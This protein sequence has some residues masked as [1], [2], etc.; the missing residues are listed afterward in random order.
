LHGVGK[1]ASR[2]V[3]NGRGIRST[4]AFTSGLDPN[5]SIDVRV[6][7]GGGG[8]DTE[9]GSLDV[10]PVTPLG[11][12]VLDTRATQI[13]DEVSGE[14]IGGELGAEGVDVVGLVVVGVARGDGVWAGGGEGVVVG[15]VYYIELGNAAW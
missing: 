10:A 5:D 9:T 4:I 7:G 3:A 2:V 14:A 13:D 12:D 11:T 15:N 1:T 6:T 8:A